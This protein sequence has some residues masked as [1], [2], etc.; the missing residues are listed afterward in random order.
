MNRKPFTDLYGNVQNSWGARRFNLPKAW[1]AASIAEPRHHHTKEA[2][3]NRDLVAGNWNQFKGKVL[4][5]WSILV[6]DHLGV[7]SGKRK[8]LAGERQSAYG[9]LRSK[10]LRCAMNARSP[11]HA[12]SSHSAAVGNPPAG[13]SATTMPTHENH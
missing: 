13:V 12:S 7:I 9:V 5:R 4:V 2:G 11:A 8:Q 6:G 3:M 10:T 1:H